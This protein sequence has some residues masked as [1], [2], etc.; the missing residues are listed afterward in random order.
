MKYLARDSCEKRDRAGEV[1]QVR[2]CRALFYAKDYGLSSEKE[3][4]IKGFWSEK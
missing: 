1:R 2:S 4:S 3:E